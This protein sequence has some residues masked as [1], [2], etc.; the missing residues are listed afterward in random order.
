[1][2]DAGDV[3]EEECLATWCA[4]EEW[5]AITCGAEALGNKWHPVIVHRLLDRGTLR[6]NELARAIDGI[7]NKVLSESLDDLEA[8]G[9]VTREVVAG[10][11]VAVEYSLTGRG[12]ALRPVVE[13][14]AA[15]SRSQLRPAG[16]G[17]RDDAGCGADAG[18]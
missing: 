13:A 4:D 15:W 8:K 5:C 10:K 3:P 6:F 17:D 14:L 7:T 9:I 18:A 1:M 12:E 11:P 16:S 2:S